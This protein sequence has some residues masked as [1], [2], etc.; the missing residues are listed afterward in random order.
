MSG[1]SYEFSNHRNQEVI[2]CKFPYN[3]EILNRF[4]KSFPSAKWSRTLKSWYVPDNMPYRNRLNIPLKEI[5]NQK[6]VLFSEGNK[7]EFIK[8]RD[9]LTQKVFSKNTIKTY[10]NEFGQLLI[11][12]KEKPVSELTTEQL[13]AY[14]LYC[15][16]KL[17][18]SENQ[19]YSRMNAVKSYFNLVQHRK[20]VFDQV[21]RPKAPN[22]LPKVLN[23][24]EIKMLF[25]AT[26]NCKHELLL[27]MAY[28]MG[29]RVSEIVSLKIANIDLERFQCHIQNAKGKKDRY[30]NFPKSL[31]GLLKEYLSVYQPKEYV[32]EGQYGGAYS[33]RSA[34]SVFKNAMKKSAITKTVG[35]HGLRHSYATHLYEIGVQMI[36]I[37]KLL[38]HNQIKTT[39]V[40]AKVSTTQLA[41]VPSS[42]DAID[43]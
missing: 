30:V 7:L 34:Q 28:G 39:E 18:H 15:I 20:E 13:N 25:K 37:Q 1:F 8:F 33:L 5:G 26:Q 22:N 43:F 42:Q 36:H 23:Q 14:F 35:I 40:Y 38:G 6:E 21:I 11:L 19:V 3:L 41:N 4:K 12:L 17:K 10:L 24:Q 32:F 9:A 31:I 29:L 16:K 2:L 27:K